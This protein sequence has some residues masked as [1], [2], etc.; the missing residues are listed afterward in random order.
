M[1]GKCW[2]KRNEMLGGGFGGARLRF[3]ASNSLD[4]C[5]MSPVCCSGSS[6]WPF[7]SASGRFPVWA[8]QHSSLGR[9]CAH[10]HSVPW[11]ALVQVWNP[12]GDVQNCQTWPNT[13]PVWGWIW[14]TCIS[15]RTSQ[16]LPQ[17]LPLIIRLDSQGWRRR[18]SGLD[19][20][21]ICCS[22][23]FLSLNAGKTCGKHP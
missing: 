20:Y 23:N 19:T 1:L 14:E 11:Q 16:P 15:S 7:P 17:Y 21:P 8:G 22:K 2:Q 10:V 9:G 3:G 5:T 13:E 12:S 6:F 4:L 18:V